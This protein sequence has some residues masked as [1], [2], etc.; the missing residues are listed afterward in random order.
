[1]QPDILYNVEGEPRVE[2]PQRLRHQQPPIRDY[3]VIGDG[4]TAAL[5]ANDGS[6]D[7][8]CLPNL[9]SPSVFGALLDE[10][11][12]GRMVLAPAVAFRSQRRYL[13]DTNVLETTF[14]TD[15]GRVRVTDA[16][17]LP[18][19]GLAPARELVRR[20]EGTRR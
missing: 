20:V 6:I 14:V 10:E 3:G 2:R 17:T 7:W 16:M 11:R 13:P 8:L 4:R 9:D 18:R 12:G 1:M 5:V 15:E 19:G